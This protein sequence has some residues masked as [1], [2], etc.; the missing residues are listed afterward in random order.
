MFYLIFLC[1]CLNCY[2]I[3]VNFLCFSSV[4]GFLFVFS[5]S[6]YYKIIYIGNVVKIVNIFKMILCLDCVCIEYELK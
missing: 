5:F 6:F 4:I 3:L 2:I 1:I